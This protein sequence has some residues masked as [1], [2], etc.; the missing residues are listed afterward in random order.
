MRLAA[1]VVL[2]SLCALQGVAHGWQEWTARGEVPGPRY[3]HSL[4]AFGNNTFLFGG[5]GS[6]RI[7]PHRPKTY[8]T[9]EIEGVTSFKTYDQRLVST[10]DP[11][12][13]N[14]TCLDIAVGTYFNDL[15]RYQLDCVRYD[16]F[17]CADQGWFVMKP[18]A[19]LG[20]CDII[21]AVEFCT[22]PSERYLHGSAMFNDGTLLVYGG[23][24]HRC[25]DFCD[26]MWSFNVSKCVEGTASHACQ[27]REVAVLG[28]TGP[29]N[30][31]QFSST[32]NNGRKWYIFGGFR[33][34]HGLWQLN[35]QDNRW[36][37]TTQFPYGGYLDDL[38][39]FDI[40]TEVWRQIQ[41]K[42]SCFFFPGQAWEARNDYV[43]TMFWP[44]KRASSVLVYTE[45][46]LWLHGGYHTSFPYP[47]ISSP[48]AGNGTSRLAG[49]PE[50]SSFPTLPYFLDD[51]WQYNMS[52]GLWRQITPISDLNPSARKGHSM[53]VA[54]QVFVMYGGYGNNYYNQEFWF[55]N[56][57]TNRWLRKRSFIRPLLPDT[58]SDDTESLLTP[59]PTSVL[60]QPTRFTP[61]DGKYGRASVDVFIPQQRRARPG[62]DGCRDR[63]DKRDKRIPR[64]YYSMPNEMVWKQ[65]S[66]RTEHRFTFAA[67]TGLIVLYGGQGYNVDELPSINTTYT[68]EAKPDFWIYNLNKCPRNCSDHGTCFMGYCLCHN[69]W[70]GVDC[71]NV[72][73]PG[74]YCH[75]NPLTLEQE[76]THCCQASYVHKDGDLYVPNERKVACD[77]QHPGTSHGICDGFGQC[78]CT[79][80]FV[81]EDC[82]IR[83]CMNNCSYA[84][85]CSLEYPISRCFCNG[86]RAGDDCSFK[87]CLNNCSYPNGICRNGVCDCVVNLNPYNRSRIWRKFEGPDCSFAIPFAGASST[88][89]SLFILALALVVAMWNGVMGQLGQVDG[90]PGRGPGGRGGAHA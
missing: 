59:A 25:E 11:A 74:D 45:G 73:C 60:G 70:Y 48:G 52:S 6:D 34:F 57:T 8:E 72:S 64:D 49:Q 55:Y 85:V 62:W 76:C 33:Q 58:C 20:G 69:G 39:E 22:H 5:R 31:Y 24:S 12:D 65:P 18:N 41:P 9:Q 88:A 30:R 27:W 38:W 53:L 66:Q 16:D 46:L 75:Y 4:H 32:T 14:L 36:S 37:D 86:T 79:P 2:A 40:D 54:G 81:G 29:G 47:H 90:G 7:V 26:D 56:I 71:S 19:P 23:F 89:P 21:D 83:D 78:Q 50:Y 17:G 15:W 87:L 10:C 43:C 68:V 77:A 35:N 63:W 42:E 67:A 51:L 13:T 44:E 1:G 82:A 3:G 28:R 80:P 61:L 84:G